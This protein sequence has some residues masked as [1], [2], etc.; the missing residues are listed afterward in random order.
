M[1]LR[2][3]PTIPSN[4]TPEQAFDSNTGVLNSLS[5]GN[6]TISVCYWITTL[7]IL[8]TFAINRLE[9]GYDIL[10][11]TPFSSE[12]EW[13]RI[14]PDQV[15]TKTIYVQTNET[16]PHT[17]TSQ[18]S[19]MSTSLAPKIP[20]AH[21]SPPNIV[22]PTVQIIALMQ[23]SLQQNA[24]VLAKFNY[25]S[26][27]HQPQTQSLAYQFKPQRSPFPK[28]YGTLSTTPLFLA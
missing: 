6:P 3:H 9:A 8:P 22:D 28:W 7:L 20:T 4:L 10:H 5:S 26:S 13:T 18:A 27:P 16:T 17:V 23:Q 11:Y 21:G 25:H 15:I 12:A 24:T 14:H 19:S 1:A 2:A